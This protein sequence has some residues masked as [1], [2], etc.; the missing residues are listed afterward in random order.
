MNE[1]QPLLWQLTSPLAWG[2]WGAWGARNKLPRQTISCR[3]YPTWDGWVS[4]THMGP[5]QH[6]CLPGQAPSRGNDPRQAFWPEVGPHGPRL[7]MLIGDNKVP[8]GKDT[9]PT[10]IQP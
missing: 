6:C 1:K 2:A 5:H 7:E 9:L 4:R 10:P 8:P 3:P